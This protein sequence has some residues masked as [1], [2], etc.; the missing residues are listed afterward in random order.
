MQIV[1]FK[2]DLRV[3]DNEAFKKAC[4]IGP[5]LPLY[6]FEK[7]LWKNSPMS[8]KHYIFLKQSLDDLNNNLEKL[9]QTLIIEKNNVIE[10]FKEYKEKYNIKTV[11]SHQETW[12]HWVK[13]RNNKLSAWFSSNN[14]RWIEVVQNGVIRNLKSREGWAKKW[15]S[16]MNKKIFSDVIQLKKTSDKM[17]KIPAHKEFGLKEEKNMNF[18]L[19]GRKE[20]LKLLESFLYDRSKNYSIEMSSPITAIESCSKLSA[21]I[22]FGTLSIKEIFQMANKRI[23]ILKNNYSKE[24]KVWIKSIRSFLKRLHWHCHFIQ[25]LEDDPTI[26]FKNMH[27]LYDGLREE[28]FNDKFFFAW[29]NGITGFPFL[30][31]CMRSLKVNGW[32]NFRMRAMLMSFASY[33]LWLHWKH[34]ADF[35][36]TLFIDYEPGIHYTQSQMQ[37]GTTGINSIRIYNPIKQ[38]K[39]HDPEGLFIKKWIPELSNIPKK[40]I[41]TPWL[42]KIKLKNYPLPIVD[43]STARKEA[44]KKIYNVR[45]S[46]KF[47]EES[48]NIYLKHG[49]RKINFQ[50]TNKSKKFSNRINQL[51]L[52]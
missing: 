44:A 41:H 2:R 38:G 16:R 14:I 12:N 36:A 35:L 45:N 51:R 46:K 19:G 10:V 50:N 39:D 30:D 25:K 3:F 34:T 40:D 4:G 48:K 29:K 5:I 8:M 37:S 33:H 1:W 21:H 18:I 24:N 49:S 22:S 43:E 31:A 28:E 17:Y 7:D 47:K 6:I 27:S 15:N 52:F 42:S 20:G 26:E 11:W 9:G 13:Q 23:E 32:I